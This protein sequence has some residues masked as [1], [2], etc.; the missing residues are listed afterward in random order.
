LSIFKN[1]EGNILFSITA[2]GFSAENAI[3]A[4]VLKDAR[5]SAQ[6]GAI[7]TYKARLLFLKGVQNPFILLQTEEVQSFG[8][9]V[10]VPLFKNFKFL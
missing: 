8:L 2:K 4:D 10:A 9:K 3:Y 5:S 1:P 7:L 6:K